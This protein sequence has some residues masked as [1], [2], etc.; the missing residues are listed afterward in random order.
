MRVCVTHSLLLSLRLQEGGDLHQPQLGG[1]DGA[2][3]PGGLPVGLGG[4][5]GLVACITPEK[6]RA[7]QT[8]ESRTHTHARYA[9]PPGPW[10]DGCITAAR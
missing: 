2:A 1:A 5:R 10:R 3:L 4:P 9:T 7:S 8:A 6:A